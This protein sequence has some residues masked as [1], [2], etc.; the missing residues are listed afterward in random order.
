MKRSKLAAAMLCGSLMVTM[1]PQA[2]MADETELPDD[3]AAEEAAAEDVT[4]EEDTRVEI[5][6]ATF[7]DETFRT[8]IATY[9]DKD[10]DGFLSYDE[11]DVFEEMEFNKDT[12]AQI[13]DFTGI[14]YLSRLVTFSADTAGIT[15]LDLSGLDYLEYVRIEDSTLASVTLDN[16]RMDSMIFTNTALTT[17][18]VSKCPVLEYLDI[19]DTNISV[20]DLTGNQAYSNRLRQSEVLFSGST[21]SN[22]RNNAILYETNV[23][24][25]TETSSRGDMVLMANDGIV[26]RL[27][28]GPG[29]VALPD[30]EPGSTTETGVGGFVERMYTVAL[31]RASDPNGK[32]DWVAAVT[33]RGGSGADVARGFLF[34]DEFLNKGYSNVNF[35]TVLYRTFFDRDP[36]SAGLVAWVEALSGGASKQEVIEGFI[37]STEFANLCLTYGITCGGTGVP[38]IDV[39]PNQATIDFATRLYTTCLGRDADEAGLMAWARQLANQRDSG[40]GAA[41]GFFFSSEFTNQNVSNAEYVNR[42]YRTFMGREADE[43][44]FNA[45]VAQL[46]SGASRE[47]VFNGFAQSNEFGVICTQYGIIR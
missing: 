16:E 42:L 26:L 4:D 46:D 11:I 2:L 31:N 6:E 22:S 28:P 33:E 36:D 29:E 17:I 18:D 10:H 13:H 15:S 47:D 39:E 40:T 7:P 23:V 8:Y 24:Q 37:N 41:R 38:N 32:E 1:V 43:A 21:F 14:R 27:A 3:P 5:T 35:V 45:W 19:L 9:A 34:S 20:L 30:Y 25:V 12:A 44:G